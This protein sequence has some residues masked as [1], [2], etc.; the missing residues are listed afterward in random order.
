VTSRFWAVTVAAAV[1]T[2]AV[3]CG[4]DNPGDGT[5]T[6]GGNPTAGGGTTPE[7]QSDAPGKPCE[8]LTSAD[9]A[10]LLGGGTLTPAEDTAEECMYQKGTDLVG[11]A[12][13]QDGFDQ[14]AADRVFGTRGAPVAGLGDHAYTYALPPMGQTHV[15]VDG[16]Y[17][18]VTVSITA[19]GVD[20]V[21]ESKKLAEK[22]LSRL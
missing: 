21:G 18:T 15:W 12:I 14:A 22:V 2:A 17:L 16:Y 4:G 9:A 11:L 5:T 3:G 7:A 13:E 8:L 19:S 6:P 10:P 20:D 1:L